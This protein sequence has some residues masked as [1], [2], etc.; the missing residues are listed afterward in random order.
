[1]LHYYQNTIGKL[2]ANNNSGI[3]ELERFGTIE[4][5]IAIFTSEG[6]DI[7]LSPACTSINLI[8]YVFNSVENK[9]I[10]GLPDKRAQCGP[11]TQFA[12]DAVKFDYRYKEMWVTLFEK[13]YYQKIECGIDK[14]KAN[15]SYGFHFQCGLQHQVPVIYYDGN[16]YFFDFNNYFA[17]K[18]KEIKVSVLIFPADQY[19][20]EKLMRATDS[21]NGTIRSIGWKELT[22]EKADLNNFIGSEDNRIS[23]L[24]FLKTHN[25]LKAPEA[26][27]KKTL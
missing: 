22:Y 14:D 21:G 23:A 17:K 12:L 26:N 25:L 7:D 5:E 8:T 16:I 24:N 10:F 13:S 15:T 6:D 20:F 11:I 4:N 9:A 3:P 1:M 2:S 27:N 19:C 18:E